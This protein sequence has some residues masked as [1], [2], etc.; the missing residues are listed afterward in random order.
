MDFATQK[1]FFLFESVVPKISA[2]NNRK[3]ICGN[4]YSKLIVQLPILSY[5]MNIF[6]SSFYLPSVVIAI[7]RW[8]V[9]SKGIP[10]NTSPTLTIFSVRIFH[11]VV[12]SANNSAV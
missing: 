4:E 1:Y 5:S 11:P 7:I 10:L 12:I 9:E 6:F 8:F 2:T 3:R